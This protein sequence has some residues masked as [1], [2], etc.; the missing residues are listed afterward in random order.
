MFTFRPHVTLRDDFT[1]AVTLMIRANNWDLKHYVAEH[2]SRLS[3][4]VRD[5]AG[6]K[7]EVIKGIV[8]A[9]KGM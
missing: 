9:A 1:G 8:T 3:K 6:L 2:M 5:T 4:H 7:E